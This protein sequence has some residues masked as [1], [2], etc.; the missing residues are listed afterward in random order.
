[1]AVGGWRKAVETRSLT[2]RKQNRAEGTNLS[3]I[4]DISRR[5]SHA[6]L[7]LGNDSY[8]QLFCDVQAIVD[9][10]FY[11]FN[12]NPTCG[13]VHSGDSHSSDGLHSPPNGVPML[14]IPVLTPPSLIRRPSLYQPSI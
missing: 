7:R 10:A 11:P 4:C 8:L 5:I 14:I 9:H 1:V 3:Q 13:A 2:G 12:L 6:T